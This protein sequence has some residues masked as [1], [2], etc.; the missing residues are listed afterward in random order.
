MVRVYALQKSRAGTS[1]FSGSTVIKIVEFFKSGEIVALVTVMSAVLLDSISKIPPP[2]A[3][4]GLLLF[5]AET[6]FVFQLPSH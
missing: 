3:S 1:I 4:K 6:C 2:R 5:L